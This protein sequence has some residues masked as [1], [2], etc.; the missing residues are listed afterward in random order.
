M[1]PKLQAW[2]EEVLKKLKRSEK[3]MNRTFK[4]QKIFKFGV[5]EID[6]K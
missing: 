2:Q 6:N 5:Y 1:V 3:I 4:I